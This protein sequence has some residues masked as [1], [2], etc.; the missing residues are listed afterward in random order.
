MPFNPVCSICT[1]GINLDYWLE[2]KMMTKTNVLKAI[3]IRILHA[4][5]VMFVFVL[6]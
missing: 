1:E 5:S 2:I 6:H 4:H 3:Q